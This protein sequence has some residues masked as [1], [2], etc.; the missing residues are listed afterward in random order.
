MADEAPQVLTIEELSLKYQVSVATIHRLKRA[1]R[2]PYF[3]PS[4]KGGALRFPADAL[5]RA[6]CAN[7]IAPAV[8]SEAESPRRLSGSTP[9]W[10]KQQHKKT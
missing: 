8:P 6:G 10:M 2:I 7:R 5:E 1:G 4:G 3:Q 9:T